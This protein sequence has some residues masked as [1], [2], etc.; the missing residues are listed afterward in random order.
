MMKIPEHRGFGD[1]GPG[2]IDQVATGAGESQVSDVG[3]R[4]HAERFNEAKVQG[5][6]GG[7]QLPYERL[8]SERFFCVFMDVLYGFYRH[9]S[10]SRDFAAETACGCQRL[11]Q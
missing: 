5:A 6:G 8:Y 10:S 4:R 2:F 1:G 9:F 3:D 11:Q 7:F